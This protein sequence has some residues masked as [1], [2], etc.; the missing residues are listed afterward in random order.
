MNF[1]EKSYQAHAN[2]QVSTAKYA[3]WK[4]EETVDYWRHKRMYNLLLPFLENNKGSNWLTI[5]DGRY[6]TDAHFIS[7]FTENV[8]AT[9]INDVHLKLAK[10]D[11]YIDHYQVENAEKLSFQDEFFDFVLCKESY[12]HFPRPSIA[13][14][15]MLRVAKR[16]VI[17]IEPN[18][19]Y[20]RPVNNTLHAS[21]L[22]LWQDFKN[23]I[24]QLA[25]R[26]IYYN[27]GNYEP[28]GNYIYTVSQR[29]FEKFALGLNLPC[30]VTKFLNDHYIEGVEFEKI[31]DNG[32]LQKAINNEIERLDNLSEKGINQPNILFLALFKEII[33]PELEQHFKRDKYNVINL[34]RNPYLGE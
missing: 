33:S 20:I 27:Y 5:G 14:Y 9:D 13:L 30:L 17:L 1:H 23:S 28:T 10:N 26:E 12:H 19:H 25:G 21:I 7:K 16:A 34:P 11:G 29:E 4:D 8:L 22:N 18:D 6:G 32:P 2:K 15:E 3:T 24:K 31:S